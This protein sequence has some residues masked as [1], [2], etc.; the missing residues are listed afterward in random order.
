MNIIE[1]LQNINALRGQTILKAFGQENDF[2]KAHKYIRKEPDGKGGFNYIY[3]ENKNDNEFERI[4]AS[5]EYSKG[6]DEKYQKVTDFL[7]K[8][9][10][11]YGIEIE[12]ISKSTTTYGKSWYLK[13]KG[14]FS[15]N[16]IRISDH[17]VG[18]KR[19][20]NDPTLA[21]VNYQALDDKKYMNN[22]VNSIVEQIDEQK[23]VIKKRNEDWEKQ[24]NKENSIEQES[25]TFIESLKE[26]KKA[27]FNSGKTYQDLET[28]KSKHPD[29]EH[30]FQKPNN[31]GFE[32]DYI[33]IQN[34]YGTYNL[35]V[36]KDYF[37]FLK[38]QNIIK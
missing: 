23:K 34:G 38:K 7:K 4:K 26:E 37:E 36:K 8:K 12:A 32:Y 13:L 25:K 18:D 1:K 2:E 27:I 14:G 29:W 35:S 10:K 31:G 24:K 3:K 20:M 9:L 5:E 6:L 11:K 21:Y 22:I 16:Q 28:I 15:D 17:Q 19:L 33:K 30:I